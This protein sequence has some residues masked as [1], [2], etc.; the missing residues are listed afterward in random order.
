ME[1]TEII[2]TKVRD[3]GASFSGFSD[4][5]NKLPDKFANFKNAITIG[6]R[7]SDSIIDDITDRP[8][9]TYF[10]HY[11]T[12]NTLIDQIT[13]RGMLLIQEYGYKALAV[14]ASQ[15]VH[16]DSDTFRGIVA[17][18]TAAVN[19]GLGYIGKSGLFISNNFGPRVRLGTI[20]TD[21]PMENEKILDG[22]KCGDCKL[23]VESCPA[24]AL[25]GNEWHLGCKREWILDAKA[26]NDYMHSKFKNIGRGSVCG[27][28]IKVCPKGQNI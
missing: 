18:K 19:A 10:H 27:I 7:L 13:L 2:K 21:M 14:A 22:Q 6:I 26:C 3:W 11:R 25:T 15:T 20:L 23:C 24:F 8:T 16:D 12:V 5:S 28:C 1:Y 4:M 9:F 17:H